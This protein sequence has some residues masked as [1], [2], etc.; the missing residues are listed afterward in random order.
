M[1]NLPQNIRGYTDIFY[2]VVGPDPVPRPAHPWVMEFECNGVW[3]ISGG[4]S[5]GGEVA[6][7]GDVDE[8]TSRTDDFISA[9][10]W[11]LHGLV[12]DVLGGDVHLS[13]EVL[14]ETN[15]VVVIHLH[16]YPYTKSLK[17]K[18]FKF[19]LE[20]LAVYGRASMGNYYGCAFRVLAVFHQ[21][22]THG[23]K[24]DPESLHEPI[25]FKTL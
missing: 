10:Q 13:T 4:V 7:G 23:Q 6:T 2:S 9:E 1:V 15:R 5:D 24:L 12:T 8:Q 21:L 14:V 19:K 17:H 11:Q 18:I 22:S 20:Y 3:V 25:K 16:A